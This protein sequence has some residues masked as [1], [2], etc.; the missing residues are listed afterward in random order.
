M[1]SSYLKE[2]IDHNN[3]IIIPD[4]GAIMIQDTPEGKQI[5]FNDFLKFND[6]LLV[7]QIIKAEKTSKNQATEKIKEFIKEVEKSFSNSQPYELAGIGFLVKDSHGNIRFEKLTTQKAQVRPTDVKPTIV[8]DE[9][10][11]AK[12]EDIPKETEKKIEI[13]AE[14]KTETKPTAPIAP[15]KEPVKTEPSTPKAVPPKASPS[16]TQRTYSSKPITPKKMKNNTLKTIII[17]AIVIII[18]GGGTWAVWEYKLIGKFSEKFLKK[19]VIQEPVEAV[20]I[21]DTL[22]VADTTP[23]P[24]IVEEPENKID[25]NAKRYYIVAG[26]FKVASNADR[27]NKK[28]TDEGYMSE[29]VMRRNGF[30]VVSYKTVYDKNEALME[31]KKMREKNPETWIYIK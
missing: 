26:S 21:T 25:P 23:E 30:H 24:V 11:K 2:L 9:V 18:L 12:S 17:A 1:I 5:T 10:P 15:P 22:V 3:R 13:E 29:I 16:G 14:Q 6:G 28:L 20:A 19:E 27:Y 4:F 8:L 31:W 7:N